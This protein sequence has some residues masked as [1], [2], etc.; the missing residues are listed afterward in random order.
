LSKL[1]AVTILQHLLETT[2]ISSIHRSGWCVVK[3]LAALFQ[4]FTKANGGWVA[5]NTTLPVVPCA[6]TGWLVGTLPLCTESAESLP[7]FY[8]I[9]HIDSD[10]QRNHYD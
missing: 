1:I 7:N 3:T 10:K 6:E 9:W 2:R 5:S 8:Q 4:E